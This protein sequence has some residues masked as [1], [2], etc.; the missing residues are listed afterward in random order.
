MATA[1]KTTK[2][3]PA[4]KTPAK[5]APAKRTTPAKRAPAKKT[6][7]KKQPKYENFKLAKNDTPFFTYK[8]T[9]QTIY[10]LVL[11]ITVFILALWV[12]HLHLELIRISAGLA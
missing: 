1:K 3:T 11:S 5:K 9:D 2:K 8:V 10:W 7:R 4:K 6:T 12:L